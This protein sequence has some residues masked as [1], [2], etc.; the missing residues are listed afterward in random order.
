MS[1]LRVRRDCKGKEAGTTENDQ[2]R[3]VA[4]NGW[5]MRRRE[6]VTSAVAD[7]CAEGTVST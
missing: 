4:V 3:V 1:I 6:T 2:N 7:D 5:T